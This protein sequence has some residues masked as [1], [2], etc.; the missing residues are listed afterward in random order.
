MPSDVYLLKGVRMKYM[1]IR[2]VASLGIAFSLAMTPSAEAASWQDL[3]WND[4]RR[5][6]PAGSVELGR[7][8]TLS[9]V[10]K[11]CQMLAN[12]VPATS[13]IDGALLVAEQSAFSQAQKRD[14]VAYGLGI[15]LVATKRLCPRFMRA[16]WT[17]LNR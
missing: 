9:Q 5:L 17:A 8:Y 11:T 14:M 15:P 10:Q 4:M 12:G 16:V 1:P 13:I 2:L 7:S 6:A 3:A